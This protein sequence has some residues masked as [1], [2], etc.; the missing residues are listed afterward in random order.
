[1]HGPARFRQPGASPLPDGLPLA[2]ADLDVAEASA[3][4]GMAHVTHLAG[5]A[6]AAIG[7]P[8]HHVTAFVSDGVARPPELVRDAGVGRVLEQAALLAALDLVGH[9]S[10]ELEVEAA[11]VD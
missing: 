2:D 4:H 6:L 3:R 11:I 7:R 9:L 10:G 1:M 5:L 8:E